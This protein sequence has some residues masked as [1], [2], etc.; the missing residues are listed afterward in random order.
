MHN[1]VRD[2]ILV[3]KLGVRR[4][5]LETGWTKTLEED[6]VQLCA[7]ISGLEDRLAYGMQEGVPAAYAGQRIF[8]PESA[9]VEVDL[10]QD[11]VT[12]GALTPCNYIVRD[13]ATYDIPIVMPG[14]GAFIAKYMTVAIYLRHY[15][16]SEGRY[17]DENVTGNQ[18]Y[19]NQRESTL[20][21][22]EAALYTTK[23]SAFRQQ[24]VVNVTVT[25]PGGVRTQGAP[26][27]A[28]NYFWNLLDSKSGVKLSDELMSQNVLLPRS[29]EYTVDEAAFNTYS[30]GGYF[31][32]DVPFVFERDGQANFQFR[33]I[34]PFF[35]QASETK[36]Q[37]IVVQVELHGYRFET[38]QDVMKMGA[39]SR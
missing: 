13:G 14:P 8:S 30:D 4:A 25:T 36:P 20:A 10:T 32:F 15:S 1:N 27:S 9:T 2:K 33:P 37:H 19:F 38:A 12:P 7:E 22:L 3:E 24:P 39:L 17:V 6:C 21:P 34:T 11:G 29:R 23:F 31:S 35:Q 26:Y 5:S 16:V 18:N 28:L